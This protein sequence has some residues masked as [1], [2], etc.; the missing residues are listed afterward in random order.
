MEVLDACCWTI[1]PEPCRRYRDPRVP[2]K[3]TSPGRGSRRATSPPCPGT[4]RKV[5]PRNSTP[6]RYSVLYRTDP[7]RI[8]LARRG[9]ARVQASTRDFGTGWRVS[10]TARGRRR[11][12]QSCSTTISA[13]LEREIV[14]CVLAH[15]YASPRSSL[16][17]STFDA[18]R[19]VLT[20][21]AVTRL[22]YNSSLTRNRSRSDCRKLHRRVKASVHACTQPA[23]RMGTCM[24]LA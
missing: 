15:D 19:E 23:V 17:A 16:T 2:E 24:L 1:R 12:T 10:P 9:S 4:S 3:V 7:P 5:Q 22:E 13:H 21:N 20:T 18:R 14:A 8:S 6:P 11:P